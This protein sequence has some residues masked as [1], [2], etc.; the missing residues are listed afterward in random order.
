MRKGLIKGGRT[1]RSVMNTNVASVGHNASMDKI[2]RLMAKRRISCVM[3]THKE[4]IKGIISERDLVR[5]MA[6][7]CGQLCDLKARGVMS[8]PVETLPAKTTIERALTLMTEKGFR[9]FPIEDSRG[10]LVGIVTQSDVLKAF[11]RELEIAHEKMKDLAIRDCLTGMFN[12][13]FFM[14]ALEKEFY[15]SRRYGTDLSLIMLDLDDFKKVNDKHGHQFGDTVLKAVA[16]LIRRRSRTSDIAARF[17]G[18]EFVVLAAGASEKQAMGLAERLRKALED[19]GRTA[20]LGIAHYP[21]RRAKFPDDLVRQSD[22]AM[23]AAK[24]AGKNR[25]MMWTPSL[26]EKRNGT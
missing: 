4:R 3:V 2:S 1:V 11:A 14:A 12:R 25:S 18:E 5:K 26:E 17:G 10:R 8:A 9:R 6:E 23:Y 15:R 7:D 19:T 21:N 24:L 16:D 13:R 20:S 22:T